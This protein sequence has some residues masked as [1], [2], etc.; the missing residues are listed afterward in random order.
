MRKA[1]G[2]KTVLTSDYRWQLSFVVSIGGRNGS[3]TLSKL[4]IYYLALI[5]LFLAIEISKIVFG[6]VLSIVKKLVVEKLIKRR[7]SLDICL[8]ELK[9]ITIDCV[10][11]VIYSIHSLIRHMN[12]VIHYFHTNMYVKLK[13]SHNCLFD[14]LG[15]ILLSLNYFYDVSGGKIA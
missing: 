2:R 6:C 3:V 1:W 5:F 11:F 13:K 9:K 15:Q 12:V 8:H 10:L 7:M 14:F 4:K